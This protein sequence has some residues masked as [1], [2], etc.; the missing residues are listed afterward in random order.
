MRGSI[1][2]SR[3]AISSGSASTS[4]F[5]PPPGRRTRPIRVSSGDTARS[6]RPRRIVSRARPVIL[7]KSVMP[8]LPI[9]RAF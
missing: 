9:F 3:A 8:P 5:R 7:D 1:R 2:A 4:G 6:S